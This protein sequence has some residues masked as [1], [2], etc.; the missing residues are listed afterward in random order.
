MP[1][2]FED[3]AASFQEVRANL[4]YKLAWARSVLKAPPGRY[5]EKTLDEVRRMVRSIEARFPDLTGRSPKQ[6]R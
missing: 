2:S 3:A 1:D 6:N 5:P 4:I